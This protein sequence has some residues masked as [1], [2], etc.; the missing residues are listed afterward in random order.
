[1]DTFEI[2][3]N[4]SPLTFDIAEQLIFKPS[5]SDNTFNLMINYLYTPFKGG[6]T[7]NIDTYLDQE[8]CEMVDSI[9][10]V[11]KKYKIDDIESEHE[12]DLENNENSVNYKCEIPG[13]KR[14][15]V[16]DHGN[17]YEENYRDNHNDGYKD[18]HKK[19][20][21]NQ[22]KNPKGADEIN[23]N[24]FMD[25]ETNVCQEG[26]EHDKSKDEN[27]Q[28][29]EVYDC[30]DRKLF[31]YKCETKGHVSKYCLLHSSEYFINMQKR[32]SSVVV[33]CALRQLLD[34]IGFIFQNNIKK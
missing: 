12:D 14:K 27:K 9:D 33:E 8:V 3:K 4:H 22:K 21:S 15:R 32:Y 34:S 13:K 23:E 10:Q 11:H 16:T 5:R 24:S 7:N 31:C 19:K 30:A 6:L 26:I 28:E 1:M 25:C 20:H 18:N 17:Y 29:N 2:E